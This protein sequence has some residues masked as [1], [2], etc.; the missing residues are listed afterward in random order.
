MKTE[1]CCKIWTI[2]ADK[3]EYERF[4]YLLSKETD[5]NGIDQ[6]VF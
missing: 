5:E 2:A 4:E 1:Q 6:A 3:A